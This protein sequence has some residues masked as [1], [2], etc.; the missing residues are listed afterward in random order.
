MSID[1]FKIPHG[2][3]DEDE[4]MAFWPIL[5]YPDIFNYFTFIPFELGSTDLSD[6]KDSKAYSYYDKG[7][8]HPLE[9]HEFSGSKFCLLK[10]KC[11]HSQAISMPPHKLWL[12]IEKRNAKV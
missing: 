4:G 7:F 2:W 6:Y 5:L 10:G 1:R 8:L 3:L 12:C 9:Y 11:E